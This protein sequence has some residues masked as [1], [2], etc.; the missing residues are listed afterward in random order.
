[1]IQMESDI[2]SYIDNLTR[3]RE[4]LTSAMQHA[5]DMHELAHMDALTGLRNRLAYDKE[6]GSLDKSI[7]EGCDA[8]GIGMVDLNFLKMINDSYGH[9]CG[10]IAI[11]MLSSV[12]CEVFAHSPV[13]RIGGDEFAIVLKNNDYYNVDALVKEFNTR[14]ELIAADTEREP[15]ERITAAFGYAI[16]DSNIDLCADD[17]FRRADK[18]M[19]ERKKAMKATRN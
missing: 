16:F 13:F 19:Y 6:I 5:D 11:R 1:M 2:D 14:L 3:T 8:F 10:N 12:I 4:Q 17:V 15:W 18:S 7:R 9:D